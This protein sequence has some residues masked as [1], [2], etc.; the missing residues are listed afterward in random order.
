MAETTTLGRSGVAVPRLGLGV[1]TWG[2]ATGIH[3]YMPAKRAYGGAETGGEQAAFAASLA[4]G[5]ELGITLIAYQPLA[6]GALTGKYLDGPRPVGLRRY[7]PMFRP[8]ALEAQRPVVQLLRTIG[9]RYDKTPG[10]VALRWLIQQ[11]GVVPI[12]GAKNAAQAEHNAAAL[13]FTLTPE[14]IAQLNDATVA[15]RVK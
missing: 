9:E 7:Q 4:A 14:E 11:D 15:W 3:R 6:S 1:M 10:Q 8:K 5:V 12:P 13:A 2:E